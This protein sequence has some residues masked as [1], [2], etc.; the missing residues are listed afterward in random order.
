MSDR[1]NRQQD[2]AGI[3]GCSGSGIKPPRNRTKA[4][5]TKSVRN[6]CEVVLKDFSRC[7]RLITNLYGRHTLHRE[8]RAYEL[9]KGTAGIPGCFGLEGRDCLVIEYIPGRL[10]GSFK[11]GE[12]EAEVFDR[13]DAIVAQ[14]HESGV[15]FGDV[16][17]SNIIITADGDVFLIDFA[18][19]VFARDPGSPGL[20]V[21]LVMELDRHAAQRMRARYLSLPTP[22]PAGLFGF[23]YRLGRSMKGVLKRTKT[24]LHPR[25]KHAH[26]RCGR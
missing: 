4:C 10:L 19:A 14:A 2:I 13:L 15:A 22:V 6:G 20:F 7:S 12:L 26:S 3:Q 16:H 1:R 24:K 8:A 5:V 17:K 9:L 23:L 25:V 18:H 11:R 21:R